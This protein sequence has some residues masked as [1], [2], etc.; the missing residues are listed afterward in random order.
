M[1]KLNENFFSNRLSIVAWRMQPESNQMGVHLID[2]KPNIICNKLLPHVVYPVGDALTEF[3][4]DV[5][6]VS[7]VLWIVQGGSLV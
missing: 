5:E 1:M 3:I 7:P 4:Y 6:C 2:S